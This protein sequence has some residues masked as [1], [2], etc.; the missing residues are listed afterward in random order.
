MTQF[1]SLG[2]NCAVAYNLKKNNLYSCSLPFDWCKL[3]LKK[4]LKVLDNN[5]VD[6]E[7]IEFKKISFNHKN[8]EKKMT[9]S[10]ILK[11]KYGIEFAHEIC[12]KYEIS[13]YKEKLKLR[14]IKFLNIKNPL[15]VRLETNNLSDEKMKLYSELELL[16]QKYF[17]TFQII[18]ISRNK[19]ESKFTRWIQ[20]KNFSKDWRFPEVEWNKL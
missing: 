4:L 3:N 11:N 7:D 15:F 20:L 18:L 14:I 10:L 19:Y 13:E 2:G 9:N 17:D 12:N 16:L 8:I 6:Y 5:F 1:V